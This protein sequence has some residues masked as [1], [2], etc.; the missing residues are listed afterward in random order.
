[1]KLNFENSKKN[2]QQL[3]LKRSF[4]KNKSF[5]TTKEFKELKFQQNLRIEFT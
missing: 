3:N 4:I 2:D 5:E 1:M